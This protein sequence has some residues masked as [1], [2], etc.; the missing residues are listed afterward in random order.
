MLNKYIL[1][2]IA[3]SVLLIECPQAV[4]A[5][6]PS[7][8][9]PTGE[10]SA[11]DTVEANNAGDED[12]VVTAR[13]RQESLLDAPVAI[14][15]FS[16]QAIER[17]ATN[18]FSALAQQTPGLIVNT[19][20]DATGASVTLRGVK[21]GTLDASVSQPVSVV[22]D[23]VQISHALVIAE[24]L[25]D[26]Q[27]IEILKG[28]QSLY[29]GK[30]SPGGIINIRTVEPGDTFAGEARIQ[31]GT[32]GREY[33]GFGAV[34]VPIT[35]QLSARIALQIR[36]AGG[37]FPN[38]I[39]ALPSAV[40]SPSSAYGAAPD[41]DEK[42]ARLTL[43][44]DNHENFDLKARLT[45]YHLSD[46]GRNSTAET[47]ICPQNSFLR[48]VSPSM[49]CGITG[50]SLLPDVSPAALA[51]APGLF[52]NEGRQFGTNQAISGS[53]EANYK[54]HD[55][56]L[57]LTSV[58]GYYDLDEEDLLDST[59]LGNITALVA[60]SK[61]RY[62][63]VSQ[64]IR[65]A[66]N[67]GGRFDFLAGLLYTSEQQ[68]TYAAILLDYPDVYDPIAAAVPAL[69]FLG[70]F[71]RIVIEPFTHSIHTNTYS[72][73]GQGQMKLTDTITLSAG[74][75]WT[76]EVKDAEQHSSTAPIFTYTGLHST[77]YNASPEITLEY[78]PRD[79]LLFYG[80]YKQGFKS[81]GFSTSVFFPTSADQLAYK[82]ETVEGGEAGVKG[83]LFDGALV[84]DSGLFFY[85]YRDLQTS[86]QVPGTTTVITTNAPETRTMGG[87]IAATWRPHFA[88]GLAL[89]GAATYVDGIY[90]DY[91][92]QCY[93][94]Q[95][96]ATGCT[97]GVQSLNGKPLQNAPRWSG[98]VGIVYDRP[99]GS[100][101]SS[102]ELTADL[103]YTGGYSSSPLADPRTWM[104]QAWRID[105]S[106]RVYFDDRRW[107]VAVI[108]R[109]L[110]NIIRAT[111]SRDTTFSALGGGTA[112]ANPTDV[113]G[114]FTPPRQIFLQVARHF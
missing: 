113:L 39:E 47:Y 60:N 109:N 41:A 26:V 86:F 81:G 68:N 42:I 54:F 48:A 89:H 110:T 65:L 99:I 18:D 40:S 44:Y 20:S 25:F 84:L 93:G 12:I 55:G 95:T 82:P 29:Y 30:N 15:A 1:S 34:S 11:N 38:H 72:A 107:S 100:T 66:S 58:S 94:S 83:K 97:A 9:L 73:F 70:A 101:G 62:K 5:E 53:V 67:F 106:V 87:E 63:Q 75:R 32:E 21:T 80:S 24:G 23:G 17:Y 57:T 51:Y 10:K 4:S 50:R 88:A 43:K 92:T 2:S 7:E 3:L 103:D 46:S 6:R 78:K 108:G 49:T 45:Y 76:A 91:A 85:I 104:S 74:L 28:P 114:Y 36:S 19:G 8:L 64:E 77:S 61:D 33:T 111:E 16:K 105:A 37:Y 27:Q 96:P 79:G 69:S 31:Y 98:N 59:Q 52:P 22:V 90:V 13:K 35:S 56:Q 14:T 102:I 112:F 71:P